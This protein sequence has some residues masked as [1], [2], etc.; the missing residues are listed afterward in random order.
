MSPTRREFLAT[1]GAI[2]ATQALPASGQTRPKAAKPATFVL[3]HGGSHGGWCWQRVTKRLRAA[4]HEVYTPTLTG[5]GERSHLLSPAVDLDM[6]ITDVVNVLKY[7]DLHHVILAGHSYGG[8]VITGVADR[9]L[10]RIGHLVFVDAAHPKNGESLGTGEVMQR[11]HREGRTVNGV[12]LVVFPDTPV[13]KLFGVTKP[14]DLAWMKGKIT[15]HPWKAFAQPIR[16]TNEAAVMKLPRTD[17]NRPPNPLPDRP[18]DDRPQHVA[19]RRGPGKWEI[20]T[21]HD[22]MITA[23]QALTDI[24]LDVAATL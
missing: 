22:M 15:P 21:G 11:A 24:L 5:L 20:N 9:A 14:E 8:S 4:G 7:E 1:V 6:H 2:A 19:V 16:L 17:I 23:P 3:V 13:T 10:D 12:E 18:F